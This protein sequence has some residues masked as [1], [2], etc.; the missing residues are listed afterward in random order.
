MSN[1]LTTLNQLH[2]FDLGITLLPNT[3]NIS[4]TSNA[5][6]SPTP[7]LLTPHLR[8]R[9]TSKLLTPTTTTFLKETHTIPLP[10]T[11]TSKTTLEIKA[12]NLTH[13]S[14]SAGPAGHKSLMQAI[15]YAPA[16][17]LSSGFTGSLVGVFASTNGRV[18]GEGCVAYFSNWGYVGQRQVID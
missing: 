18:G 17:G 3:T 9:S 6:T 7:P 13:Y 11:H 1:S 8:Y 5:N 14:F 12:F 4:N 10:A 15:A 2:H 16:Q